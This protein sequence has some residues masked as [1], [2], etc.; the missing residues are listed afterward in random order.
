MIGVSAKVASLEM[1]LITVIGAVR[2]GTAGELAGTDVIMPSAPRDWANLTTGAVTEA[3]LDD[4]VV[5]VLLP[6]YALDQDENYPS[7]NFDRYVVDGS[8][9]IYQTGIEAATLLKNRNRAAGEK[10]G[11]PLAN[12]DVGGASTGRPARL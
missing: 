4:Q 3:R 5:R 1:I 7:I 9:H 10:G 12:Q 8:D 2:N 11:L 6:Y